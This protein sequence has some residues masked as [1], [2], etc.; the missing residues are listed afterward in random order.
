[1]DKSQN[2][3]MLIPLPPQICICLG[4]EQPWCELVGLSFWAASNFANAR[5]LQVK[6]RSDVMH[7]AGPLYNGTERRRAHRRRP[8]E[9]MT[10]PRDA[11]NKN[12]DSHW[13]RPLPTGYPA[14]SL[15]PGN[16]D[17]LGRGVALARGASTIN[18]HH[19]TE[20]GSVL[21]A[22]MGV[23]PRAGRSV[24]RRFLRSQPQRQV[25][26]PRAHGGPARGETGAARAR[27]A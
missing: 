5:A 20:A 18:T 15:E 16:A 9:R 24:P 6:E 2:S 27:S 11:G 23:G 25:A 12:I 10:C 7:L 21:S 22:G 13:L 17:F 19:P 26:T 3:A 1:M 14:P 4:E 8:V